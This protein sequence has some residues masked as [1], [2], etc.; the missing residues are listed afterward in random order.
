[1]LFAL[2]ILS[3]I[4]LPGTN[5]FVGE[6]LVLIGTFGERPVLAIIATTGVV[7]A[8]VY[9]LRALQRLLFETHEGTATD[10]LLDL[11]MRERAVMAVFA[12]AIVWLGF[13][14]QAVLGRSERAVRNVVESAHFGPN[15]ATPSG[16]LSMNP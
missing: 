3:T 7:I 14:P 1:V 6:F 9:G 4:G 8:A 5:G 15:A 12:V 13:V 16:N 11:S 2:S 10:Q